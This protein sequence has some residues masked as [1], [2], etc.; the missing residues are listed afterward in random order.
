MVRRRPSY[1]KPVYV[2]E[3]GIDD[4]RGRPAPAYLRGYLGALHDAIAA[5]A[6]VRGYFHWSLLDNYEWAEGYRA[7]TSAST[8]TTRDAAADGAAERAALRAH[9]PHRCSAGQLSRGS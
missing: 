8:A 7:R 4:A 2:T 1:G 3:N 6:D 9:R 5:G